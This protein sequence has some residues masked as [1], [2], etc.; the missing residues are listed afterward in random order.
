MEFS[1]TFLDQFEPVGTL[2]EGGMA[3]VILANQKSLA[4]QVAIKFMAG[5]AFPASE[6][7]ERFKREA[8]M[9]AKLDHPNVLKIYDLGVEDDQPFLVLEY[10]R[11]ETVR[12]RI[13]RDGPIRSDEA[14]RIALMVARGLAYAHDKSILH[15]DVKPENV[16]LSVEGGV[17]LL[18]FGL[19]KLLE[20]SEN[21][22]H[23]GVIL[24][25]PAYLAP[26]LIMGNPPSES[27]D[28]YT[29]GVLLYEMLC[30]RTPWGDSAEPDKLLE[31]TK[32]DTP[33]VQ[34]DAYKPDPRLREILLKILLRK[35]EERYQQA[36]EIVESLELYLGVSAD[37]RIRRSAPGMPRPMSRVGQRSRGGAN[38]NSIT[39]RLSRVLRDATIYEMPVRPLIALLL[40]LGA[41]AGAIAVLLM[42]PARPLGDPGELEVLAGLEGARVRWRSADAYAGLVSAGAPGTADVTFR[43]PQAV[44]DHDVLLRGLRRGCAYAVAVSDG[45]SVRFPPVRMATAERVELPPAPALNAAAW[46]RATVAL[47]LNVPAVVVAHAT[48]GELT[49]TGGEHPHTSQKL[50]I[51]G[52][53]AGA[54]DYGLD[55]DITTVEGAFERRSVPLRGAYEVLADYVRSAAFL[56]DLEAVDRAWTESCAA[57]GSPRS[58][59]DSLIAARQAVGACRVL[60]TGERSVDWL[61]RC[62]TSPGVAFARCARVYELLAELERF[63][64][65]LPARLAHRKG[66]HPNEPAVPPLVAVHGALEAYA[67][68]SLEA[69][70]P[71]LKPPGTPLYNPQGRFHPAVRAHG[72]DVGEAKALMADLPSDPRTVPDR[73]QF[74]AFMEDLPDSGRVRLS[75]KGRCLSSVLFVDLD[76][77]AQYRV[78]FFGAGSALSLLDGLT[79]LSS[80]G[81]E[82]D[83]EE[84]IPARQL[85]L[86][87][88]VRM[89]RRGKNAFT[90]TAGV[91]APTMAALN[92]P[93][94][95]VLH[96]VSWS[97]V[98]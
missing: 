44:T 53:G 18:D 24:G 63:N 58:F 26:E 36:C 5:A 60:K 64:R 47:E 90:V 15:R 94:M 96:W 20:L 23:G 1:Q 93:C 95:P 55:L 38:K 22:S 57:D 74:D 72:Q 71:A 88:P 62:L 14:A 43:E 61:A 65:I 51:T 29:V 87:L 13:N 73:L 50:T 7:S 98:R 83:F 2:G 45:S 30:G 70:P 78:R 89:F 79:D 32:E 46:D 86:T 34:L 6:A 84:K 10:V 9:L 40:F 97:P 67:E 75:V 66:A 4:R 69:A 81:N 85:S 27:S 33:T 25:T 39:A 31:R 42:R 59:S 91:V 28:L 92:G 82:K 21:I 52:P 3:K 19:G 16:L 17:K 68:S 12:D 80:L 54:G 8:Q 41:L 77:N 11:G 76:V 49:V 35:P 48:S 37:P 56:G